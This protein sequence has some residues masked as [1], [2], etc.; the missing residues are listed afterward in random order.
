MYEVS[1]AW[2]DECTSNKDRLD[3]LMEVFEWGDGVMNDRD[4]WN[5]FKLIADSAKQKE[6]L[7]GGKEIYLIL[8]NEI[9]AMA[10]KMAWS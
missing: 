4:Q 8:N 1:I 6:I 9:D 2:P 5:R 10:V 7:L 3:F